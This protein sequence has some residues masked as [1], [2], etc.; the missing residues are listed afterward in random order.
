MN[1]YA[2]VTSIY[3]NNAM[4]LLSRLS[5]SCTNKRFFPG[6]LYQRQPLLPTPAKSDKW[7]HGSHPTNTQ[8]Y[9][10]EDDDDILRKSTDSN[11]V[12]KINMP[13]P[14]REEPRYPQ[15]RWKT[16]IGTP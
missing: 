13:P 15:E 6:D 7:G 5:S 4:L 14:V 9:Y 1:I 2:Y 11:G 12:I 8:E 10:T 3:I 16:V